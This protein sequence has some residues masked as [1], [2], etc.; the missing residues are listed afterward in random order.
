MPAVEQKSG[1]E[2]SSFILLGA[3]ILE[4]D[5]L[6]KDKHNVQQTIKQMVRA[7]WALHV[8]N[9]GRMGKNHWRALKL[10]LRYF[11]QRR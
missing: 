7:I 3:E 4:L 2:E 5:D 8:R 10:L 11:S 1:L 9:F 6:V